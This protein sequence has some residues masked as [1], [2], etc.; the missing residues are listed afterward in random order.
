[1]IIR[2][3]QPQKRLRAG[4]VLA[5][6]DDDND[7]SEAP[8]RATSSTT[9]TTQSPA[10]LLA[11]ATQLHAEASEFAESANWNNA[12]WRWREAAHLLAQRSQATSERVAVSVRVH[13][14][15]AQ[16]YLQTGNEFAAVSAAQHALDEAAA[17]R[18]RCPAALLTRARAQRNLGELSLAR[19]SYELAVADDELERVLMLPLDDDDRA[20]A[21]AELAEVI[22]LLQE[23]LGV[24][25]QCSAV[26][27]EGAERV[28]L[29]EGQ[30]LVLLPSSSPSSPSSHHRD[31]APDPEERGD[32]ADAEDG[33]KL[34][35][36][37]VEAVVLEVGGDE[38]DKREQRHAERGV[39]RQ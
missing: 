22:Q 32:D 37:R 29:R 35:A 30:R 19:A 2:P 1:M 12:L 25:A 23:A 38:R 27:A 8:T 3:L 31:A 10:E 16:V 21:D 13:E 20:Q 14:A 36:V 39:E 7:N 33:R 26:A 18:L 9:T 11:H 28:A 34:G 4:N 17:L 24:V 15:M 6:D 5:D